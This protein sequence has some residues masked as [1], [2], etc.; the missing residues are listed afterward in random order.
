MAALKRNKSGQFQRREEDDYH[1]EFGVSKEEYD[2]Y[3]KDAALQEVMK[4]HPPSLD[5]ISVPLEG[6]VVPIEGPQEDK[7]GKK[8]AKR[9]DDMVSLSAFT[10]KG[11]VN[12]SELNQ[13]ALED[14]FDNEYLQGRSTHSA[15][16]YPKSHWENVL[17]AP[18]PNDPDI[19]VI[20]LAKDPTAQAGRNNRYIYTTEYEQRKSE[21]K[22]SRM[23]AYMS[24]SDLIL[25][26][27]YHDLSRSDL[28]KTQRVEAQ[29]VNERE[30][31][32][33]LGLLVQ[34]ELLLRSG[35]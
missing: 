34:H 16:H 14:W 22:F 19:D 9:A 31:N 18:D 12:V 10:T 17:L 27:M 7:R 1:D 28:P 6:S 15:A 30:N 23:H 13:R 25:A 3:L 26:R 35:K 5:D 2:E 4:I 32:V 29:E 11:G 20:A 33:A 8:D 24:Y 21:A